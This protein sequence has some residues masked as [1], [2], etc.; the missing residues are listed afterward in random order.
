[1]KIGEAVQFIIAQEN[2]QT[3][4][5]LDRWCGVTG[6]AKLYNYVKA[7]APEHWQSIN[8]PECNT[9]AHYE[10][11]LNGYAIRRV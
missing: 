2:L 7:M 6:R 9:R 8:H 10:R 5:D 3:R 1:M 4:E 11:H